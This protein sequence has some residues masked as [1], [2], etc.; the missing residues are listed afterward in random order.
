MTYYIVTELQVNNGNPAVVSYVFTDYNDALA[1]YYTILS[2]A[3]KSTLEVHG[4]FLAS[5]EGIQLM[6]QVFDRQADLDE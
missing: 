1:K 6:G 3:C 5:S 4:A 2:V